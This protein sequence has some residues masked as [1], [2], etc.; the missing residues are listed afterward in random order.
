[1]FFLCINRSETIEKR[2]LIDLR[3]K[4]TFFQKQS[5]LEGKFFFF[6]MY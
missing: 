5:E 1:M 3:K 2:S 4:K 6:K